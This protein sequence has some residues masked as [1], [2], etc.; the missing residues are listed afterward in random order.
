MYSALCSE[1]K[2]VLTYS[3]PGPSVLLF[4]LYSYHSTICRNPDRTVGRSWAEILDLIDHL[5]PIKKKCML[6]LLGLD[7]VSGAPCPAKP[8]TTFATRVDF[9]CNEDT[10]QDNTIQ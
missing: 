10:A 8:T 3:Q 9:F 1:Y 4:Y 6:R 5:G 2:N 7:L